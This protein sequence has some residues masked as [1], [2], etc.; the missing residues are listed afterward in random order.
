M[1]DL[2]YSLQTIAP[3][4]VSFHHE[5]SAVIRNFVSVEIEVSHF[6]A[7]RDYYNYNS[8]AESEIFATLKGWMNRWNA[9]IKGDGSVS[10]LGMEICTAPA[11]GFAF[12]R[13][14]RELC[15]IFKKFGAKADN[16]CG[17][18]VHVDFRG[19]DNVRVFSKI[20]SD[21]SK[22]QNDL[23]AISGNRRDSTYCS[24]ISPND[25]ET[26]NNRLHSGNLKD[27]LYHYDSYVGR[28][29]ALNIIAFKRHGTIE[30]RM[31]QGEVNFEKIMSWVKIQDD[32]ATFIKCGKIYNGEFKNVALKNG[33]LNK[34]C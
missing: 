3:K 2:T 20:L 28:Y 29:R 18:H 15:D 27:I 10:N 11:K 25:I 17:L 6:T 13:Q 7:L 8:A 32:F 1:P 33:L 22:I 31:H 19:Y 14:L 12:I 24:P 9:Q 23:F 4:G 16:S 26:F 34:A 30:N 5:N 21:F